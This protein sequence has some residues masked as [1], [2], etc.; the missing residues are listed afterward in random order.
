[1]AREFIS[2]IAFTAA[3]KAEQERHGSR[4]GYRK[5]AVRRDWPQTVSA[6][7][8]AFIAARDSFYLATCNAE[9]QP[10]I[11][12]R[13]GPKGFLRVVDDRTLAIADFSGNRQYITIG[14]L[15]ENGQVFLFLM[16]YANQ[17]RVKI[18]ARGRVDDDPAL[19][20]SLGDPDYGGRPERALV[21]AIEAWDVNCP[22][23]I[24][25]RFTEP[26]IAGAVQKLQQRIA[27][28][29]T[30]IEALRAPKD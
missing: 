26:E 27:D 25:R 15:A 13:G 2:D 8:A 6:D 11:Q 10:Y 14:N 5:V 24:T 12:H 29:E 7:L 20:E 22:Q 16:D 28:L 23:H 19:L 9:G 30:E 21:F 4:A 17:Q 18:W 1:M 3:V